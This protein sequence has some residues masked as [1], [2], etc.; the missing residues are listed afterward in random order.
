MIVSKIKFTAEK[1]YYGDIKSFI[2]KIAPLFASSRNCKEI[3]VFQTGK[4]SVTSLAVYSNK[5][6]ANASMSRL[7]KIF[8]VIAPNLKFLPKREFVST[9]EIQNYSADS[10]LFRKEFENG[11]LN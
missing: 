10:L 2:E 9:D 3:S 4:K 8:E 7:V 1:N 5:E 6:N 11:L